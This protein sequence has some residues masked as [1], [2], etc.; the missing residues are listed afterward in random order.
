M[1]SLEEKIQIIQNCKE[2]AKQFIFL[3]DSLD[4]QFDKCPSPRFKTEKNASQLEQR[5]CNR[6]LW[7]NEMWFDKR[8]DE[9][10]DDIEFFAFHELRHIHQSISVSRMMSNFS[11]QEDY[12]EIKKWQ[13]EF[14]HYIRNVDAASEERNVHQRIEIDANAYALSLLNLYHLEDDMELHPSI[15]EQVQDEIEQISNRYYNSKPELKHYLVLRNMWV[16]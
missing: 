2:F 8:I 15:P 16:E 6:V 13:F 4:V 1:I 7:F 3:P 5:G 12:D 9:H 11:T 10:M 14:T